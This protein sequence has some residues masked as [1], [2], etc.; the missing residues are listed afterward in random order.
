MKR[1]NFLKQSSILSAAIFTNSG[2]ILAHDKTQS[3][4]QQR[5]K[6]PRL[7]KG[8]TVGIIAPGGYITQEELN[9]SI[10]N[11]EKLGLKPYFTE[12]IL[13]RNGYLSG[14]DKQRSDDIN[15]MFSNDKVDGII[16]SRGGYGCNRILPM[17]DYSLIKANPKVLVGY[18]DITALHNAIFAKTGLVTFHGPV[19]TST[20]NDF[21][22]N[23]FVNVLMEPKEKYTFNHSDDYKTGAD[24]EIYTIREGNAEGELVGGNLRIVTTLL[25]TPYDVDYKNKMLFLEEIDE[26]PY[27]IDRMLTELYLAG[28][29]QQVSAIALGVFKNCDKKVGTQKGELTFSLKEVLF[30]RLYNLGVP[31]IYGLSFGH[32]ENKYTLPF[33]IKAKLDVMNK[34]IT[35]EEP[36][37]V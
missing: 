37:V 21:S 33:G 24:Y 15:H 17:L 29:L 10:Q 22:I 35:L 27:R 14:T 3:T 25:G 12:N 2:K 34:T 26:K 30:D 6:P 36:A 32:I 5:I 23:H 9:K 4:T 28:K 1:R 13:E 7:K 11:V 19:A 16:C 8:D 18:S 20:F 31:V